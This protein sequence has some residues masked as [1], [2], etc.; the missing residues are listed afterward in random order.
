MDDGTGD[1]DKE[2]YGFPNFDQMRLDPPMKGEPF[3]TALPEHTAP[4]VKK[5]SGPRLAAPIRLQTN[6]EDEKTSAEEVI[7][8][9]FADSRSGLWGQPMPPGEAERLRDL[10]HTK[11]RWTVNEQTR[12]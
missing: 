10:S 2:E 5:P 9:R 8:P 12:G 11:R 3:P 1:S 6:W 4:A 7:M